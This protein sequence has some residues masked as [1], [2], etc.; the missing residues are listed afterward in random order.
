[1]QCCPWIDDVELKLRWKF[2]HSVNGPKFMMV[3]GV[4]FDENCVHVWNTENFNFNFV[5]VVEF[6]GDSKYFSHILVPNFRFSRNYLGNISNDIHKTSQNHCSRLT[7]ITITTLPH[8]KSLLDLIN[9]ERTTLNFKVRKFM[10]YS[11]RQLIVM[12]FF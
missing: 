5:V 8:N 1:M 9:T 2:M 7:W 11:E 10:K 3:F 12:E 4:N 6:Y